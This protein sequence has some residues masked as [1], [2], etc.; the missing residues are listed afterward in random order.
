[1]LLTFNVSNL[2]CST[3]GHCFVV[4]EQSVLGATR[5]QERGP[6]PAVMVRETVQCH[7]FLEM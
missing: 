7:L 1:M 4:R 2:P 5:R 6:C 3:L